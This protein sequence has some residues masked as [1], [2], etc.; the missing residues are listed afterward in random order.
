MFREFRLSDLD[1][2]EPNEYSGYDDLPGVFDSENDCG[3]LSYIVDGRTK[4]IAFFKRHCGAWWG[5]FLIAKHFTA[6]DAVPFL[7]HC[8]EEAVKRGIEEIYTASRQDPEIRRWHEFWRMDQVGEETING[9]EHDI[10]RLVW[11]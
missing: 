1:R 6:R 2:F 4:A 3:K 11:E 7:R 9:I 5:F 8:A 10:W